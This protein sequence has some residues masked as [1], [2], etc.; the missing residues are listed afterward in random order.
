MRRFKQQIN[1]KSSG[2][3]GFATIEMIVVLILVVA[4]L[5]I[6]S[7]AMFDHA[8]NMAGQSAAD[9]QKIISDAASAY[10]KD[11]YAAV[12]NVA[13]PTEPANITVGMLKNTGY[14]PPSV[15]DI[16]N[17]GQ[18]YSVLAI[19]PTANKLQTL[20][21][22]T[23]GETIPETSIRRISKQVGARGGYI[24]NIDTS[25][26]EGTYGGWNV[27]LAP[28]GTSPG[29]G[30]LATALFFDDGALT[31]DYLYRNAVPGH[32]EVNEMNTSIDM[33]GNN[34]NNAANVNATNVNATTVNASNAAVTG[35]VKAGTTDTTGETY[36]GGWFKTRG[37]TGWY[38][39]KWNGGWYMTDPSW[40]RSYGDKGVYTGGAIAGGTLQSNGRTT[41]G[42]YLQLNGVATEGAACSPN[43]L[44]GR[45]AAGLTLSCQSGA[46]KGAGSIRG[47]GSGFMTGGAGTYVNQMTGGFNCPAGLIPVLTGGQVNGSCQ[48][49]FMYSCVL[50]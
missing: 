13:T 44:V 48:P 26:V 12:L 1:L 11:N 28:Y 17:F 35:T 43:G 25:V 8:D 27:S 24:S 5:G 15:T 4:A 38:N 3:S 9:H 42:E 10:I 36:T 50:P 22:T 18:S 39:E 41:V 23:G 46:W 45:T 14:L 33:K 7:Q 29:E 40:V 6:G 37:D 20:V 2:Q 32:P 34:L 19:K 16:N 31:D 49:C 47:I 30:H 21:I